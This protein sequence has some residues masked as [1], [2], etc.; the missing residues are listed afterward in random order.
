MDQDVGSP[1][2][3]QVVDI[4]VDVVDEEEL[5]KDDDPRPST[6]KSAGEVGTALMDGDKVLQ[7]LKD[8]P[9]QNVTN[10]P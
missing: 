5:L 1:F 3:N 4:E 10:F 8:P 9:E 2:V 6:S 7:A